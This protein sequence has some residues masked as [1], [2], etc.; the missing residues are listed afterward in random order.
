MIKKI[1]FII[2][3]ISFKSVLTFAATPNIS[4]K[5]CSYQFAHDAVASNASSKLA[6]QISKIPSNYS[7]SFRLDNL[8]LDKNG[9]SIRANIDSIQSNPY[10][11]KSDVLSV[12]LIANEELSE[13]IQVQIQLKEKLELSCKPTGFAWDNLLFHCQI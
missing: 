1:V 13:L 5:A 11:K 2:F 6:E 12:I 4:A 3:C 9:D 7:L 10:F 8:V